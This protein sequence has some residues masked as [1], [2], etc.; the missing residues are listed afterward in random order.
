MNEALLF[1]RLSQLAPPPAPSPTA[2]SIS[3]TPP[4]P[5]SGAFPPW[6][7]SKIGGLI[8]KIPG[9]LT[10]MAMVLLHRSVLRLAQPRGCRRPGPTQREPSG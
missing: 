2:S 4:C 9:A 8:V 5:A 3:G 7:T 6:P 1:V 10:F